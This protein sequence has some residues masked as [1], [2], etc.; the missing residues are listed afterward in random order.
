MALNFPASPAVNDEYQYGEFIYVWDGE[1]WTTK[2]VLGSGTGGEGGT[3]P[4]DGIRDGVT[5]SAP[6][7]NAVY[8]GLAGKVNKAGDTM[9][10]AL[11]FNMNA[12]ADF[13]SMK[14]SDETA[15]VNW[16]QSTNSGALLF[17]TG[18][19]KGIY[20][21]A[22][23][24]LSDVEFTYDIGGGVIH[25]IYHEGFKPTAADVGAL[26]LTGGTLTGALTA[27]K[28]LLSAAQS[29]EVNSLTRKDYVDAEIAAIELLPG[30][31]GP[32]GPKGD[33]GSTGATGPQGPIGETGA[34][35]AKGDT[36]DTGPQGIQGIQGIPG[37]QGLPGEQGPQGEVGETGPQGIQGIQGP[38]GLDGA[39]GPAGPQGEAGPQGIQ[40]PAGPQGE[41]GPQG[42]T[43][44]AS[45]VPG[46]AGPTGPAG[47]I[48]ETG[49]QGEQGIQGIPGPTGATGPEGPIGETGAQ[50]TPGAAGPKGDKGDPG[51]TGAT[52]PAG[53]TGPASTVP[54]PAGPK[55]DTGAQGP[56]G[57]TGAAGATGA[58]GPKGDTGA[59]GPAGPTGATGPQGP[60][61]DPAS[62]I[63]TS[64]NGLTGAVVLNSS[65]VGALPLS[66]GTLTGAVSGIAPTADAH[67]ATKAYVDANSGGGGPITAAEGNSDIVAGGYGQ[68]GTYGLMSQMGDSGWYNVGGTASGNTIQYS[69]ADGMG[70]E[71]ATGTWKCLGYSEDTEYGM[72]A[73]VTTLW[74]RIV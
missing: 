68:V 2:V 4:Y 55:G 60:E 71:S 26:S 42:P 5:T 74:I 50:G 58:Q 36:G 43:G 38:A 41:I 22:A 44:A 53:P 1:K 46:P 29:T 9:T 18:T 27:P 72:G 6:T 67:L 63:I 45:T 32:A 8:D 33:T 21:I 70:G 66:G 25:N 47:P 69:A 14:R 57:D 20:D 10:G 16:G 48:G 49:P 54:G 34:T 39:E 56:K 28:V 7:E 61:G 19:A 11:H 35:G 15:Y 13:I 52:G 64:V 24:R 73:A 62:N 17:G 30:P 31:Q 12:T 65:H 23:I 51:A 40:G 59:T 3:P 37:E